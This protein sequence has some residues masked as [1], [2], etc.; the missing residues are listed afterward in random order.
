MR[1]LP[2][3]LTGLRLAL[4]PFALWAILEGEYGRALVI[5]ALAG[6]TDMLDG[7]AAR[8]LN[9]RSRLGA[10][11]DPI[12]DKLLLSGSY[13]AMGLHGTVPIWLLWLVLGRDVLILAMVAAALLLT[14]R[15]EFPPSLWGK[16]STVCQILAAVVALVSG[17]FPEWRLRPTLLLWIAAAATAWSGLDYLWRGFREFP[18]RRDAENAEN[19]QRRIL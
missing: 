7:L 8:L 13:V 4:T 16:I 15:R 5:I 6:L 14:T 11:M 3:L 12:A 2:N 18:H 10:Y 9:A 1:H 19:T 17:A